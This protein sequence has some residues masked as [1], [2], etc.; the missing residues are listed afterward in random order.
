MLKVDCNVDNFEGL[1][2]Y[3]N[4]VQIMLNMKV[5][6]KFQTFIQDK[7]L[8]TVNKIT[9]QRLT[10]GTTNDMAIPLYKESNHI[11]E[12]DNGFIL[13]N[14]AKISA[15]AK[16]YENYP[17]GEF[18]I[19]LAFEYG[20]G[21]VGE[22]TYTDDVFKAWQYNVNNYNFG[23]KYPTET[24][25]NVYDTTYGYMGFEIY[26][27]TAIEISKNLNK[28]INEYYSKGV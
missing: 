22:G 23:W 21:I 13:Y 24:G 10:G 17:N 26:R 18:S 6:K 20:V 2:K 16:N 1:K 27:Y 4:K 19:A 12:T 15:D 25:D 11:K 3:I 14:D 5:D 28:W 8:E 7:C 9:N